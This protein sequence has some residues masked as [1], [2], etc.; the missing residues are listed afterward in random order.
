LAVMAA[1]AL[2]YVSGTFLLAEALGVKRLLQGL[3]FIPIVLMASYFIATR[4]R[5]LLNPLIGFVALK[6]LAELLFRGTALDLFDDFATLFALAVVSA[7]SAPAVSR[8]VR[9][10]VGLAGTLALLALVQWIALFFEPD[11]LDELL[12]TDDEGKVVGTVHHV[13][14][15]LGLATGEQYTLFGHVVS[16]LQSW[17][18][19]PSLNLVYFL[20][21]SA[22]AF[23]RGGTSGVFWGAVSLGFCIL[24]LS[25][26]V[27]LSLAFSAAAWV[28]L[29][30]FSVRWVLFWGTLLILS[31]YIS[32]VASG[33]LGGVVSFITFLSDYGNFMSKEKSFT[34][35]AGGTA[36]SLSGIAGAPLGASALPDLPGPWMVNGA[37]AAGWLGAVMLIW[38]VRRLAVQ[39]DRLNKRS[40]DQANVRIGTLVL[41]GAMTTVIVFNDYQMGNYPGLVLLALIYRTIEAQN[42]HAEVERDI[43]SVNRNA[44]A[45]SQNGEGFSGHAAPIV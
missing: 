9:F 40:P 45:S 8:G 11:L 36:G 33:G 30:M 41:I 29:R 32:A 38:F 27:L 26:S 21:P 4:P 42:E 16:R 22:M 37:L 20:I 2:I 31:A 14:A 3:F 43:F 35:R 24:S 25:G 34:Y 18:K 7:A 5:R 12:T 39:L 19:E 15:L 23:M 44:P 10:V 13:I 17:A 28:G 6:T 1:S